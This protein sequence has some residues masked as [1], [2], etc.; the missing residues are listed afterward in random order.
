MAKQKARI[1]FSRMTDTQL[2]QKT[3]FILTRMTGNPFFATP[4]PT[5]TEVTTARTEFNA[6]ITIAAGG[7]HQGVAIK[8]QS[9]KKLTDLLAQLGTYVNNVANGDAANILGSGFDISKI[10]TPAGQLPKPTSL[11]VVPNTA[12]TVKA[13][14]KKIVNASSYMFEYTLAPVLAS[15]VWTQ[16][17]SNKATVI[18]LGLQRGAEYSFRVSPLGSNPTRNF[19]DPVSSYVN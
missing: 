2:D 5:L 3:D 17:V 16:V 10:P 19:S 14:T 11:K 8:N 18:I 1:S 7:N 6:A 9:R 4:I 13:S 15:S 12:G